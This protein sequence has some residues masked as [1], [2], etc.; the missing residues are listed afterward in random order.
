MWTDMHKAKRTAL[1]A[2]LAV[3]PL[4]VLAFG[5][6]A[7][8]AEMRDEL[9]EE[10][11]TAENGLR[12][13]E[14]NKAADPAELIGTRGRLARLYLQAEWRK[15]ADELHKKIIDGFAKA[16]LERTG[17]PEAAWAAE[18]QFW[19]LEPK[20]LAAMQAKPAF[21]KG[22]KAAEQLAGQIR[23]LRTEIAGEE[24]P[25]TAGSIADRKGGLC[26]EYSTLVSSYRAVEWIIAVAVTQARLLAHVADAIREAPLPADQSAED[27]SQFRS[28]I[29]EQAEL[30]EL[31]ALHLL[32]AA[33]AELGRRNLDT[34]WRQEC[35]RELNKFLPKQYPLSRQR[36]ESWLT[37]VP[38]AVQSQLKEAGALD[39]IQ[40]CYDR[41]IAASSD[42]MLGGLQV[43]FDVLTDGTLK[44]G[45]VDHADPRIA[46]CLTRKWSTRKDFPKQD[47]AVPVRLKLEYATL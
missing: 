14:K 31:Q 11:R 10:I 17:G 32:E 24:V 2:L 41:H 34:Q 37:P 33:W 13:L 8:A 30:F 22:G 21:G 19:V 47:A 7:R 28:I 36:A 16:K 46:S 4:G 3:A 44:L 12:A 29:A 39:D 1:A 18:A 9:K 27:Q 15:K 40:G 45:A 20:F 5:A 26:G 25:A 6:D 23:K 42:E 35:R 38:E 43:S